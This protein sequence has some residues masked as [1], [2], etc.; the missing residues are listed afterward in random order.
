MARCL[1]KWATVSSKLKFGPFACL[2]LGTLGLGPDGK[3][4]LSLNRNQ[5]WWKDSDGSLKDMFPTCLK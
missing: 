5:K 1:R 2:D 4:T 3:S